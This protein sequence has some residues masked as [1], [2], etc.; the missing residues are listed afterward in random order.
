MPAVFDLR[1]VNNLPRPRDLDFVGRE[2]ILQS[3]HQKLASRDGGRVQVVYGAI[4]V[5]KTHLA[6][7]FA[8]RFGDTFRVVWWIP[9]N[10]PEVLA[11]SIASLAKSLDLIQ[12]GDRSVNVAAQAVHADLAER[13][14]WLLIFDDAPDPEAIRPYLPRGNGGVLITS[15]N[16]R[17]DGVGDS[18]CLRPLDRSEAVDLL[19]RRTKLSA[20]P[21]ARTLAQAL[22]DLP[23]ALEQAAAL[24]ADG[25]LSF[26]DY[27]RRFEE[28][29]AELLQSGRSSGDYPDSLLMTWELCSRRIEE[30]DP[31]IAGLL[32]V[33]S[34]RAPVEVG[35]AYLRDAA[36]I[37]PVPLSSR[38]TSRNGLETALARLQRLSLLPAQGTAVFVPPLIASLARDRLPVEQQKNWCEVALRMM[39]QTFPFDPDATATW[40]DSAHWLPHA[41]AVAAHAARAGVEPALNAKLLNRAGQYLYEAGRF[42]QARDAFERALALTEDFYGAEDPRCAAIANNLG[43]ALR[44]VGNLA[45][46]RAQFETAFI[47]DQAAYGQTHPHVAESANNYGTVLYQVGETHSALGQ[48]EWALEVCQTCYGSEHPKVAVVTNNLGYA[49]AR[50]GELDRAVEHFRRAIATAET[51]VGADHPLVASICINL[52]VSLRL[53]GQPAAARVQ[54]QRAVAIRESIL[55]TEHVDVARSL[56]QLGILCQQAGDLETARQYFQQALEID[57]RVLGPEHPLI[58]GRLDDLGRCMKEIGDVDASASCYERIAAILRQQRSGNPT[59]SAVK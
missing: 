34:F 58:V 25:G 39:E 48:F 22:G 27:L 30:T 6:A 8:Y 55:G 45:Q 46:A 52:G 29:W 13:D 7:E 36:A 42:E 31:E 11:H 57:G 44:R 23:L 49:L 50:K 3:L 40:E 33:L 47:L 15:R 24:I 12:E 21:T 37:L 18:Y 20:D 51:T 5:G 10:V 53:M 54:L 28:H 4:G 17:W 38:L 19:F 1:S 2:K 43:R 32:K 9:A 16:P 41:L 26:G 14:D 59:A 56:S 35:R